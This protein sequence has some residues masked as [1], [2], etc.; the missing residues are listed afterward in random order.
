MNNYFR[1]I[2]SNKIKRAINES[3]LARELDHASL[4]GRLREIVLDDLITPLLNNN[5]SSGRGK[6]IDYKGTQSKEIDICIYSPQLIPPVFFT[7][8]EKLGIFPIESVLNCIEVKSNLTKANIENAYAK[9]R[10]LEDSLVMTSGYHDSYETPLSHVFVKQ[11][12]DIFC[13]DT[14]LKK[15]DPGT[16]LSIYKK[17]DPGWNRNPLITSICLAGKGW[18]CFTVKGWLHMSFDQVNNIN[19]EI[20]GYL[21]TLVQSLPNVLQTR[22]NPRIGYYLT[23]PAKTDRFR[24]GK[25][26]KRPW[27]KSKMSGFSNTDLNAL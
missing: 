27:K 26:V 24:N 2:L 10:F 14:F 4:T 11:K 18:L 12:Y 13:F 7:Q 17:I 20:I 3:A 9:F 23:D 25:L 8:K 22:G 19:E 15:Y 6:V 16:I 21:C 5:Y 1:S